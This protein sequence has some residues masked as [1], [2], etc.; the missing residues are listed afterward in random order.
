MLASFYGPRLNATA[1]LLRQQ[2]L[3]TLLTAHSAI[4]QEQCKA[5]EDA[6]ASLHVQ[7]PALAKARVL[8]LFAASVDWWEVE[9]LKKSLHAPF[10][11]RAARV[12]KTADGKRKV[13]DTEGGSNDGDVAAS[14]T[15]DAGIAAVSKA[16]LTVAEMAAS[17][18]EKGQS[19]GVEHKKSK[20]EGVEKG[21][22]MKAN[23]A[24]GS[25]D[26]QSL[27]EEGLADSDEEEVPEG[28]EEAPKQ[29]LESTLPDEDVDVE[30]GAEMEWP[31]EEGSMAE[32]VEDSNR[33]RF[34][35]MWIV[36]VTAIKGSKLVWNMLPMSGKSKKDYEKTF[37]ADVLRRTIEKAVKGLVDEFTPL[38]QPQGIPS[39]PL[40]A[41]EIYFAKHLKRI[42][43]TRVRAAWLQECIRRYRLA[44]VQGELQDAGGENKL[45]VDIA[46]LAEQAEQDCENVDFFFRCGW[47]ALTAAWRHVTINMPAR[48]L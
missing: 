13:G 39:V 38:F 36:F 4:G 44:V 46:F 43:A 3:A 1:S 14:V 22:D 16:A 6:Q 9:G 27:M 34:E 28:V 15:D 35:A 20:G 2:C 33:E 21:I 23:V 24:K 37:T 47:Y 48:A 29:L 7:E 45:S 10:Q 41:I 40:V 31:E 30:V 5:A 25:E 32:Q 26:R 11:Y 42:V 8:E 19:D 17:V 12:F 18:E